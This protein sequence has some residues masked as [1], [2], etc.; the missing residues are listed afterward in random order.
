[1][2]LPPICS[3]P[4]NGV[5][6]LKS[7]G[8]L[9][10]INQDAF[11]NFAYYLLTEPN[12]QWLLHSKTVIVRAL[13]ITFSNVILE[14]TI[15]LDAFNG[16]PDLVITEFSA[17][18][19]SPGRIDIEASTPITS[20]A[21]LGVELDTISF[22]LFFQGSDIGMITSDLGFLAAKQTTTASFTG[23]LKSQA[24][25]AQGLA[26]VGILFSQYLAGKDS[27][28]TIHGLEVVTK[29]N[30][31]APVS[32]LTTAFKRFKDTVILPGHIY[33][34]IFSIVLSDLTVTVENTADPYSIPA[35]NKY[36]V[37]S[38]SNPLNF[39][40]HPLS[41]TP[42]IT[43]T[44][45]DVDTAQ[46][47]LPR[48][49][50]RAGTS[51]GPND[52]QNITFGFNNVDIT[53][54]NDGSFQAFF[55]KLADTKGANFGLKGSTSVVAET[56][57][58]NPT[59]TGIPF[60]VMTS[61][62][63]INSFNGKAPLSDLTVN[64]PTKGYLG[65]H[66]NAALFNPSN[67]TLFTT[68]VSLPVYYDKYNVYIGRAT[69]PALNLHPGPNTV[70]TLFEL[71]IPGNSSQVQ[72]VLQLYLQSKD[73]ATSGDANTVDISIKGVPDAN[74]PLSPYPALDDALAGISLSTSFQGIGTR[75][76][77]HI[78]VYIPP[79]S[80]TAASLVLVGA[81]Q[82]LQVN[83]ADTMQKQYAYAY[84]DS[85]NDLPLEI[86]FV[87]LSSTIYSSNDPNG[88]IYGQF[89]HNFTSP[90]TLPAAHSTNDPSAASTTSPEI[91]KIYLPQGVLGSLPIL[92]V[93]LNVDN[94]VQVNLNGPNGVFNVPGLH[95]IEDSVQTNI[96]FSPA[97][98]GDV[99]KQLVAASPDPYGGTSSA[100][101]RQLPAITS[102]EET[103]KRAT[104][105]AQQ[106]DQLV[107]LMTKT[108]V[109]TTVID[110]IKA[111]ASAGTTIPI[112]DAETK[113]LFCGPGLFGTLIGSTGCT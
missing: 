69:I 15:T 43:L 111:K 55:A 112:L 17:P 30:G 34:I 56:P 106:L 22:E 27:A 90:Y 101:R 73:L 74:P 107:Q 68:Q 52:R 110:L 81:L 28:L 105:T 5:P 32:W 58:G 76:V 44:Y 80:L 10:I 77:S 89:S 38:F 92:G 60:N 79:S 42:L 37:A 83:K 71:M 31:N 13:D 23:Y 18:G 99:M 67:I 97:E 29:A 100:Q 6:V 91:Q 48:T 78:R 50:V 57:I 25:S 95:Y 62:V 103:H 36:T 93:P 94:Y 1:L 85:V 109:L 3:S 102:S 35:S 63:G 33:Q 86:D 65:I 98:T 45:L 88:V 21:S 11:A 70:A 39:H 19:D 9:T 24:D 61:L 41:V 14:K 2:T 82:L 113:L 46:I 12:F 51:T 53:S 7:S 66:L 59:I 84:I 47:N 108:G 40:L 54:L 64:D 87:Q 75:L 72:E 20:L 104:S 96:Y 8:R 4:P 26:H 49:D 16:I